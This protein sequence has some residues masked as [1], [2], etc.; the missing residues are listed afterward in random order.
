[1]QKKHK[2][3]GGLYFD[4]TKSLLPA[5]TPMKIIITFIEILYWLNIFIVPIIFIG[6]AS[7]VL[8][9]N[10]P[11]TWSLMLM[12][13]LT[14]ASVIIGIRWAEKIRKTIGCSAFVNR[15][16]SSPDLDSTNDRQKED[17]NSKSDLV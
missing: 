13:S 9:Y 7:F 5:T 4:F 3:V 10:Y 11:A 2:S 16:F 17:P 1:L 14:T 8:Y 15:R 6:G 12:I